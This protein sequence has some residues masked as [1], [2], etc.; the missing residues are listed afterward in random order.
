MF[1]DD[2]TIEENTCDRCGGETSSRLIGD[3]IVEICLDCGDYDPE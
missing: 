3:E 1:I 2:P